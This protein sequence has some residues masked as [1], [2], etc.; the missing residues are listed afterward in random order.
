MAESRTDKDVGISIRFIEQYDIDY[1]KV[2]HREDQISMELFSLVMADTS[3]RPFGA[4][5]TDAIE[6]L[7]LREASDA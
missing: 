3:V 7:R 4:K 6:F 5:L 2:P 1:D